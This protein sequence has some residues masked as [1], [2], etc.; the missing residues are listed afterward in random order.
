MSHLGLVGDHNVDEVLQPEPVL[1]QAPVRRDEVR[2]VAVEAHGQHHGTQ[3][4]PFLTLSAVRRQDPESSGVAG[5]GKG[6]RVR[7]DLRCE[8][9]GVE[10]LD[11]SGVGEVVEVAEGPLEG[12]QEGG[13]EDPEDPDRPR[14]VGTR[15]G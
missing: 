7:Q 11:R 12:E 10:G 13:A 5:E 14:R 8:W 1:P 15:V 2:E 4:L 9:V 6:R 3:P